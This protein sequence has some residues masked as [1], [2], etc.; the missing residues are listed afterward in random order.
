M[1]TKVFI[2]GAFALLFATTS[3]KKES[4]TDLYSEEEVQQQAENV[5]DPATA[6]LMTLAEATHDFGDVKANEK[7]QAYVK[8]TNDGKSPLIIQDAS[9]TCGCTVP[10][11]PKTP[12]A[13]GATDSI[14]VEYTAGNMNGKQQKTVTLK[15][16]TAN[17]TEQFNITANVTGATP[18][19]QDA[20]QAFGQ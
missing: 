5:V 10:E 1:K 9:A 2:L 4:A 12:I 7:V 6:P 18:P 13:V 16:N 8:F 3:C 19:A 14:K 17:G 11:F 20:Q 15:T